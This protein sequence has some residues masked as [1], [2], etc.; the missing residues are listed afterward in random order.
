MDRI[1][2]IDMWYV[3]LPAD[4]QRRWGHPNS[5]RKNCP[6]HLLSGGKGHNKPPKKGKKKAAST[7]EEDRLRQ[8]MITIITEFVA[9]HNPERAKELLKQIYP[10]GDPNDSLDGLLGD[11]EDDSDDREE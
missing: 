11:S 1:E 9:P 6:R 2:D 4:E 8:I 3:K 7:A 10:G 5:I